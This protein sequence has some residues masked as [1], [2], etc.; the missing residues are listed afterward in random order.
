MRDVIFVRL[1]MGLFSLFALFGCVEP[2]EQG[3]AGS[4]RILAIGDSMLAWNATSRNSVSHVVE[5]ALDEEV[6]D[7]S[8]SGAR[9]LYSLPISGALG[10]RISSQY[11]SGDWDWVI[12]NGGGNDLWLGCGCGKCARQMARMI[13]ANGDIGE[14]PKFIGQIRQSGAKVIY[15]GY[16][17][18]PGRDSPIDHCAEVGDR[19]ESRLE[20]MAS[21][22]PGVFF[23]SNRDLVPFGDLSFHS[24]DRIHPSIKGSAAIGARVAQTISGQNG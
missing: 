1:L 11:V 15:L 20:A 22:D 3:S 18:T 9:M 5:R 7:R 17:R 10:L 16:L 21:R 4:T 23:L 8:V 13:S 12:V 24:L 14:I 6:L 2:V 19:F